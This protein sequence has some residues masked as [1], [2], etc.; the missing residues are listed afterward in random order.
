MVK[1]WHKTKQK[2]KSWC[3]RDQSFTHALY[4]CMLLEHTHT[5][6]KHGWIEIMHYIKCIIHGGLN[7]HRQ[8]FSNI[9]KNERLNRQLVASLHYI[10]CVRHQVPAK[11]K[12]IG[13]WNKKNFQY[14]LEFI[15]I[16]NIIIFTTLYREYLILYKYIYNINREQYP[17]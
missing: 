16:G 3:C 4:Y 13:L 17:F 12:N 1:V 14:T 10:V 2:C 9:S 7:H 5:Q 11:G 15:V 8:H 6:V